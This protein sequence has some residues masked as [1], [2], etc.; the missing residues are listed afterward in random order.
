MRTPEGVDGY[1][2]SQ[3]VGGPETII[4]RVQGYIDA[5]FDRIIVH[6]DLPSVPRKKQM[7]TLEIFAKEV[8]PHFDANF[9]AR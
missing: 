3:L 8:A 5:G 4:K 9:K 2:Y 1:I 6:G 7:E